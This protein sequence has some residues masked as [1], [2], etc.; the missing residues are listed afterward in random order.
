MLTVDTFSKGSGDGQG[1]MEHFHCRLL[2]EGCYLRGSCIYAYFKHLLALM[3]GVCIGIL[4]MF[5]SVT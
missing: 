3:F 1:K 4:K 5:F 2:P